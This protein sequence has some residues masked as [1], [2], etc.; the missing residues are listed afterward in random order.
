M[1]FFLF[2]TFSCFLFTS[3]NAQHYDDSALKK[4]AFTAFNNREYDSSIYY[5]TQIEK[6]TK[7]LNN[8]IF[9][10]R[11]LGQLY[12]KEK[13][14][15]TKGIKW[16]K[17]TVE[18]IERESNDNKHS[19]YTLS[20][21][22]LG[23]YYLYLGKN[24]SAEYFLKKG[25]LTYLN[26]KEK[27]KNNYYI[28]SKFNTFFYR[29]KEYNL[30]KEIL[31]NLI[32]KDNRD[33]NVL[34]NY[35]SLC[36]QINDS[37]EI[38]NTV[39]KI[40][41]LEKIRAGGHFFYL[42]EYALKGDHYNKAIEYYNSYIKQ[43]NLF[44]Q[45]PGDY[46]YSN[47]EIKI[48]HYYIA[49]TYLQI[50][51]CYRGL[52]NDNK[53]LE[54][55]LKAKKE[56]QKG[57]S[58]PTQDMNVMASEIYRALDIYHH[59]HEIL[60]SINYIDS[61]QKLIENQLLVHEKDTNQ[62]LLNQ[63]ILQ[64]F[65]KAEFSGNIEEQEKYYWQ[66]Y[67]MLKKF[68]GNQYNDDDQL[69]Q[70]KNLKDIQ[71]QFIIFFTRLYQQKKDKEYLY[72]VLEIIENSKSNILYKRSQG[73]EN[74][75]F[76]Q[77]INTPNIDSL[78]NKIN[79]PPLLSSDVIQEYFKD[80]Y[81]GKSF[82]SYYP[83][84]EGLIM[85]GYIDGDFFLETKCL[86]DTWNNL[87]KSVHKELSESNLFID[88]SFNHQLLE[89]GEFLIPDKL[90][91]A[92]DKRVVFSPS[93]NLTFIPFEI[94]KSQ[95]G[96]YL[97]QWAISYSFSLHHEYSIQRP[98]DEDYAP[99]E[100]LGV[101]PYNK[102]NLPFSLD[103]LKAFTDN[104]LS[105]K[106]ANMENTLQKINDINILHLATHTTISKTA[107]DS[108][109]E[110]YPGDGTQKHSLSFNEVANKD[111]SHLQ[112]VSLS[113]C[114]SADGPYIDGEGILSLQRAFAYASVHSILASKWDVNDEVSSIIMASF[115]DY[116]KQGWEKDI[117][118]QKAKKDFWSDNPSLKI[119]PIY[120]G[121]IV[122]FG[123]SDPI[124]SASLQ[125]TLIEYLPFDFK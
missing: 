50:S 60:T 65:Y 62:V 35:L 89:I 83:L 27:F 104:I 36:I 106:E 77:Y 56:I 8:K 69:Y 3:V 121:N 76:E 26:N 64:N 47:D 99:I 45:N 24:D 111:L 25:C 118:L 31:N 67:L 23:D 59:E 91:N 72:K 109:I 105:D 16:L 34:S 55:L 74:L 84:K 51:Q 123:D 22:F 46:T 18:T 44:F 101:A 120:W 116:I 75:T 95:K 103:E 94:L 14:D 13:L 78:R 114:H 28:L 107:K 58:F 9:S 93:G 100:I 125:K 1:K 122:L 38:K 30:S 11:A 4:K 10:Q 52:K 117:A 70:F 49:R 19:S 29:R 102:I 113:S 86:P 39:E 6:Q 61:A 33:Y 54:Y 88:R 115:Y 119:N 80:Y 68:V 79:S 53:R 48:R 42:G 82:V 15:L 43:Y 124:S 17:K 81:G 40:N 112:L 37:V 71:N 96:Y 21:Q 66:S 20:L 32:Q 41:S 90:K 5:F 92:E 57:L 87:I 2:L 98:I 108:N 12:G 97:D 63:L 110:F 7:S 73:L 85:A